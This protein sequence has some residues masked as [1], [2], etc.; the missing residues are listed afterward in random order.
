MKKLFTLIFIGLF[1]CSSLSLLVLATS[2]GWG[3]TNPEGN[4]EIEVRKATFFDKII[5]AIKGLFAVSGLQTQYEL[6]DTI[7]VTVYSK[8][9][10]GTACEEGFLVMEIYNAPR[11]QQTRASYV[12]GK[13]HSIG[14]FPVPGVTYSASMSYTIPTSSFTNTFGYT[15]NPQPGTWSISGYIYCPSISGDAANYNVDVNE[16]NFGVGQTA[17]PECMSDSDCGTDG[18]VGSLFCKNND[19]YQNYKTYHCK[20]P[21]Q[22]T[23]DCTSSTEARLIEDCKSGY[24]CSNGVCVKEEICTDTCES[25]GYECGTHIICGTSVDCGPCPEGYSCS[26]GKCIKEEPEQPS[27]KIIKLPSTEALSTGLQGTIQIQNT[28][29]RMVEPWLIEMQVVP[30]GTGLMTILETKYLQDVCDPNHPENVHKK[31]RLE[32]GQTVQITL[33]SDLRNLEWGDYEVWFVGRKECAHLFTGTDN[34]IPTPG[35]TLGT[36]GIKVD[37]FSIG[38]GKPPE[39]KQKCETDDDCEVGEICSAGY[40]IAG[41]CKEPL[42]YSDL[43]NPLY[44]PSVKTIR[45][46]FAKR[47]SDCCTKEGYVVGLMDKDKFEDEFGIDVSTGIWLDVWEFFTT[48]YGICVAS[49][50]EEMEE[51]GINWFMDDSILGQG[52]PNVVVVIGGFMIMMMFMQMMSPRR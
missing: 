52:I 48:E 35:S 16:L 36:I 24:T 41:K 23:A 37:E 30:K 7:D 49:T 11:D 15:I 25:L 45:A 29:A 47:K 10:Y 3:H 31:F 14:L 51:A 40:C 12:G 32:S 46:A 27:I 22:I 8:L 38:G 39:E 9:L 21:G 6:G 34:T 42:Y 50:E 33:L 28:G 19:V 5:E 17:E 18:Y 43:K 13:S 2:S 1:L 4:I 26:D 44:E 20:N